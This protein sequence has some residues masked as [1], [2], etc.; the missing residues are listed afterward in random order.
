MVLK[1]SA[2][3]IYSADCFIF[4]FV[5]NG[6][7]GRTEKLHLKWNY[8]STEQKCALFGN[9]NPTF[10]KQ[11]TMYIVQILLLAILIFKY[12]LIFC[13]NNTCMENRHYGESQ[14][15]FKSY[16]KRESEINIQSFQFYNLI[17]VN[18]RFQQRVALQRS[19]LKCLDIRV[20]KLN[21]V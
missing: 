9:Q 10:C 20:E 6:S 13:L 2:F 18:L 1:R 17:Y 16:N 15:S 14:S 11:V 3:E 7:T 12:Y 21:I 19:E 8:Y 4:F 5:L